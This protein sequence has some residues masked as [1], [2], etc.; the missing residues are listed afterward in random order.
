MPILDDTEDGSKGSGLMHHKSV[1][2][3]RRLVLTG[4]ANFTSSG[5]HGDARAPQ[6]RGNVNHLLRFDSPELTAVFAEEFRR[7]WG[8]GPGGVAN[9]QFGHSKG[10]PTLK[11][12]QIGNQTI[13]VL[14][15]PHGR[16]NP[17]QGLHLITQKLDQARRNIDMALFV[18]SAQELANTLQDR[19]EKGIKV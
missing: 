5:I 12:V 7:M 1:V 13:S 10:N 3:D 4:S 19:V 14:S 15:A 18:F 8:D 16:S 6:T 11:R 17:N 2:I 9:S